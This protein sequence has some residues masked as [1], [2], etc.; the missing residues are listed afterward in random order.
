[1]KK[2]RILILSNGQGS[3]LKDD[4]L[5]KESFE[6]EGQEVALDTVFFD[7]SLDDSFDVFI[8]RN[9]WVSKEEDT[10]ALYLQNQKLVERLTRKGKKTVNLLGNDG[11][12]KGYL[13]QLFQENY[14]VIPTIKSLNQVEL[15]P[16]CETYVVKNILSFGNGLHQKYVTKEELSSPEWY[17]EGDIIQPKLSF[18]SEIQCYYVG[19]RGVYALEYTPSKFPDYPEPR[20]ITLTPEEQAQADRFATWSGLEYGFQRVDFLRMKDGS[21]LMMEIEDHAAFMNLQRL[22]SPLLEEVLTLFKE[23]IYEFLEK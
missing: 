5:L 2:Y 20:F 17:K 3:G 14:P 23:N 7:E 11:M 10:Q 12:G 4:T 15:L 18:S 9:T 13:C 6:E 21:L 16:V 8:R 22:P 19:G 1:M